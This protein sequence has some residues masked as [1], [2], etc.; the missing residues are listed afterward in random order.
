MDMKHIINCILSVI[1]RTKV[2]LKHC[3]NFFFSFFQIIIVIFEKHIKTK[4][5]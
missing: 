1:D 3:K 2:N 5:F 4:A